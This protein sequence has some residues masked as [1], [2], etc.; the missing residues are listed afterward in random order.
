MRATFA[1]DAMAG[2]K[3]R[4]VFHLACGIGCGSAMIAARSRGD[5]SSWNI[6]TDKI[7][8]SAARLEGPGGVKLLEFQSYRFGDARD[9]SFHNGRATDKGQC[10]RGSWQWFPVD[11]ALISILRP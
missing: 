3:M 11:H 6:A 1:G 10:G 8:E 5:S 9:F 7:G 4:A 2:T